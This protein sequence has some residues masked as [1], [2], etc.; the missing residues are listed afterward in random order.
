MIKSQKLV[1][2]L[3]ILKWLLIFWRRRQRKNELGSCYGKY[4]CCEETEEII[5]FPQ[6]Y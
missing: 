4:L 5:F 6:I 2:I 3:I 1:R